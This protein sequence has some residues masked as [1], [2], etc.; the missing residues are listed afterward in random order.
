MHAD[1]LSTQRLRSVP[2]TR[3]HLLRD[4]A[5][6][7]WW[8]SAAL[9]ILSFVGL[10]WVAPALTETSHQ[11]VA[12]IGQAAPKLAWIS[13]VFLLAIPFS[14]ASAARRRRQVVQQVSLDRIRSM[15]WRQF[16]RLVGEAYR[17]KGYRVVD[18]GGTGAD[19][20]VDVELRT[21]DKKIVVQC[22]RWRTRAVGVV[23]VR[24][25][26]GAMVGEEAHAAIF[27]TS[28][29]FTPEAIEFALE[30]PITLMDGEALLKLLLEGAPPGARS[31]GSETPVV[32]NSE[33][34]VTCPQCASAMV[35][36]VARRGTGGEFWGCSQ[37]P[38]CRGTR[39]V[40][41]RSTRTA[42]L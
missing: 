29:R 42:R 17:R 26:Y 8:F 20:G 16:E 1:D 6:L 11:P 22:K 23:P 9:A 19:G 24:E 14:I 18:R 7:P 34:P 35:R 21:K 30:K 15:E 25:L 5:R 10:R 41:E 33:G 39:A 32:T 40:A 28:G 37:F 12:A 13:C 27:V 31:N 4:L 2:T 3:P 36:R 38:E